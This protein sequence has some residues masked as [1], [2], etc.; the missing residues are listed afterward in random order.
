MCCSKIRIPRCTSSRPKRFKSTFYRAVHGGYV[1]FGGL[2][3][4][5]VGMTDEGEKVLGVNALILINDCRTTTI[6]TVGLMACART[7][8]L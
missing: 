3:G 6:N 8:A 2:Y 7:K 5:A 4:I 1:G